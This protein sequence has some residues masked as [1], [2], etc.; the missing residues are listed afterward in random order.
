MERGARAAGPRKRATAVSA[1][2]PATATQA[3]GAMAGVRRAVRRAT[4]WLTTGGA[5]RYRTIALRVQR[6]GPRHKRREPMYRF[7]RRT[8]TARGDRACA[9]TLT[10]AT[11]QWPLRGFASLATTRQWTYA[12][13]A[14]SPRWD[15]V[16]LHG[17]GGFPSRLDGRVEP[18]AGGP[19]GE[20]LAPPGKGAESTLWVSRSLIRRRYWAAPR[21]GP[22]SGAAC[23]FSSSGDCDLS[24]SRCAK[25]PCRRGL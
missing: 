5:G 14:P 18:F 7:P 10:T 24:H 11:K 25:V 12:Q 13:A 2:C 4:R 16:V 19:L 17:G 9:V 1:T 3:V 15:L 6:A 20:T 8:A 23:S 22:T 21:Q